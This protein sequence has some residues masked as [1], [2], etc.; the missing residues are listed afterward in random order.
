MNYIPDVTGYRLES[1]LHILK[2]YNY[3]IIVRETFGKKNVKSEE[4]R[5]VRQTIYKDNK[6]QLIIAYF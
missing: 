5:I 4:A 1:G 3:E 2:E 6:L